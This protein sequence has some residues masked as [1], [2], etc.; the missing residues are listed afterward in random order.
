[1]LT[2]I[3]NGETSRRLKLFKS[4]FLAGMVGAV[5]VSIGVIGG[6]VTDVSVTHIQ[7]PLLN[8]LESNFITFSNLPI[9]FE[10][11]R[12]KTS[13]AGCKNDSVACMI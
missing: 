3:R 13:G 9:L 5:T 1:M 6:T 11:K 8:A 4:K 7:H 12:D 2:K 10:G